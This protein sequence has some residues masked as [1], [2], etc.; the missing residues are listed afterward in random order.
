MEGLWELFERGVRIGRTKGRPLLEDNRW[1]TS[2]YAAHPVL[3]DTTGR[4]SA[5]RLA[6]TVFG[7]ERSSCS[8]TARAARETDALSGPVSGQSCF[9]FFSVE[10]GIG[11]SANITAGRRDGAGRGGRAPGSPFSG[12]DAVEGV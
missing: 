11:F 9:R 2:P 10:V 1:T 7:L 4:R 5:D 12:R 6:L 3:H 8:H